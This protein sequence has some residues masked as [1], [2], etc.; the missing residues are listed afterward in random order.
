MNKNTIVTIMVS[1]V[2]E[3]VFTFP[4]DKHMTNPL[5]WSDCQ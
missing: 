1:A 2:L 5:T 3:S 4:Q